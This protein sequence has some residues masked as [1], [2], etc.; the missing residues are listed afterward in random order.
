MAAMTNFLENKLIDWLFRGQAIGITGATAAAGTGPTNL[1]VGLITTITDG[2][3]G[4]VTEVTGTGYGR[5]TFA[6]TTTNWD[7]TQQANTT[8]VSAGVT[9][10]TRNS[11]PVTFNAPT[12]N[13]TAVNAVG[14]WDAAA[15]GNLLIY[16]TLTTAKTVNNGDAA[17]SFAINAL[18]FQIDN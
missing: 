13:W 7:N 2:D 14:I 9:G 10:T 8:A 18:T 1:Y 6:S 17:P 16:S 4:T 3:A 15:A 12:G 11:T 5:V